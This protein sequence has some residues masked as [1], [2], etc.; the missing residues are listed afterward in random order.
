MLCIFNHNFFKKSH[1]PVKFP[2]EGH[3]GLETEK[4]PTI[5]YRKKNLKMQI[6]EL[7]MFILNSAF[8][9]KKLLLIFKRFI[10]TCILNFL[11]IKHDIDQIKL[12]IF[13]ICT[14]LMK[15]F[16]I[17][18]MLKKSGGGNHL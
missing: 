2:D 3:V 5:S 6:T 8:C 9:W 14:I 13:T 1:S 16:K 18:K 10:S 4:S 11:N 15:S 12:K 7:Y 17:L